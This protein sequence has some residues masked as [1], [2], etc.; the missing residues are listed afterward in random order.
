MATEQLI[1]RTEGIATQE[2]HLP[3]GGMTCASCVRRVE[4]ALTKVAGVQTAAVNLATERA[5]VTYDPAQVDLPQLRA[6]V[7]GAGYTVPMAEAILPIDGMTCASCVR[8]VEKA[9]AKLPGVETAGVNLATEQATVRFN[10]AMVGRNEFQQAVERAGYGLRR[11]QAASGGPVAGAET[12][13]GADKARREHELILLRNKCAVSLAAGIV[14]MAGMFLPL[15][16]TMTERY[17]AML[18]LAT[19]V[20]FWAGWGFYTAAWRAAR[21]LATNMNTLIAVGTSAAYFYSVFV[22]LFPDALRVAG[23]MPEAYYDT[24]TLVIGLILL[25]RYFEARAKSRTGD[26]IRKLMGLVPPTARVVR[27]DTEVDL[28][29]EQVQVGDILRVRPGDKVPV[30]GVVQ[31]GRSSVDESMLTGESLPV[32]K[33]PGAAV[34][35]ATLNKTGSFTFRATRVGRDTALAQI[36]RMVEEAQGSKAPIQRLA[37]TIS[38]YF[39]PAVLVLSVLTFLAWYALGPEPKFTYALVATIAVLIIACPCALGLATPT[40]I[41]VGTGKGAEFGV[42]IRGGEALESAHKITAIVLDKTGTL[43]RGKPAVTDVLTVP[44][45]TE[46]ELLRLAA[47]AERG[48]EHPL[49]EAIVS[50]ATELAL[51]LATTTAFQA[52][53]GLGI[54]ATVDGRELLLGNTRLLETYGIHLDGLGDQAA[55]LAAQGKT[56]MY[57]AADGQAAGVI[58]VADT[59]K[60]ESAEAVRELQALGLEVWMLTGD[61][62]ATAQT[63]AQAV[64]IHNVLAEVLPAQKADK[65]RELQAQGKVEA[66][67]GDGINDAPA[68]AQ[69][70]LGVAIGTGADVAMEASD[71]TLV[72]GDVR[73]VVTAIALSRRTIGTIRQNLFW[74]FFYNVVLIPVAAGVLFPLFGLLLNPIMAGAAMA[75]SSVSVVTNS[76]RLRGFRPPQSAD[77]ILHPSLRSR[78]ADVSYLVIIGLLALVVGGVSLFLFRPA[79]GMAMGGA[80]STADGMGTG[81]AAAAAQVRFT[82][83]G[84]VQPGGPVTLS[85]QVTDLAG[86]PVNP[87]LAHERPMHLIVASR[88]L[89][90][91]AH[92][93][94]ENTAAIGHYAVAYTFPAAGDYILYDELELAGHGDEVHRFDLHVGAAGSA[95]ASLAPELGPQHSGEY[96]VE[97]APRG[98]V[99]AGT[100][101]GFVVRVTRDGKPVT[102]LEPYLGAAAHVVA[103][104]GQAGGFAHIHGISGSEPPDPMMADMGAPPAQFGPALAFSHQFPTPGLYKVW[105]QFAHHGEVITVAWVV[106]AR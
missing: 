17:W 45:I 50:R 14:I 49:G 66:M 4:R 9:L 35:G 104:D 77:E 79:A 64:G 68:L 93:H 51:P 25:G 56:P 30:D 96:T 92:L 58:A 99:R 57:V 40:A 76:L 7:E 78:V 59:L 105:A 69:A 47:S 106:E 31:A 90:Q 80:G 2:V 103:L 81:P 16:W 102:D 39:V 6:A 60:P 28:P 11:A 20:Q 3:I 65:I 52:L 54:A 84:T 8:R 33:A 23:V 13:A 61:N 74:A 55:A 48:S 29:L 18:V 86:R 73:G 67:V 46:S 63:I 70:D 62:A 37:D 94:P 41:M 97:L 34:I 98:M 43:T 22:T 38:S 83:G 26:A 72:G 1:D 32:E 36:V 91:F 71:I 85:F 15:P 100:E 27:G 53:A 21:H 95:A 75:M 5:T 42:L 82:A 10:P 101:S 44:G 87:V 19:P 89:R 24:S 12:D 88:D